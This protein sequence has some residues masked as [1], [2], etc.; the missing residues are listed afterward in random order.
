MIVNKCLRRI[1]HIKGSILRDRVLHRVFNEELMICGNQVPIHRD[2][3]H[4]KWKWIGHILWRERE[5]LAEMV[6]VWNPYWT[7]KVDLVKQLEEGAS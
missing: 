1:L 6:L 3:A 2:V 4:R 7:Q 5:N